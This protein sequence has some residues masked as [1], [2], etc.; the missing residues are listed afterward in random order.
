MT[1]S[2]GP[3][4]S[5]LSGFAGFESDR[6]LDPLLRLYVHLTPSRYLNLGLRVLD[7]AKTPNP[8]THNYHRRDVESRKFLLTIGANQNGV[9]VNK[10]LDT[11]PAASI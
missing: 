11:Q 1:A 8:R 5:K 9:A 10:V 4:T 3:L 2:F 7:L 6:S